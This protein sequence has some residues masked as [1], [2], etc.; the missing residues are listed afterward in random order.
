M[1]VFIEVML[2]VQ[3]FYT[4]YKEN[5]NQGKINFGKY[6]FYQQNRQVLFFLFIY[7]SSLFSN[8]GSITSEHGR[9]DEGQS[10]SPRTTKIKQ[11]NKKP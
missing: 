5:K 10:N 9:K 3:T 2:K 6:D 4:D 8:L 11:T 7:M 1:N